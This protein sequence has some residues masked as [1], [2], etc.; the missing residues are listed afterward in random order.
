MQ[1]VVS[2]VGPETAAGADQDPGFDNDGSIYVFHGIGSQ[3]GA[4]E[5]DLTIRKVADDVDNPTLLG[6]PVDIAAEGVDLLVAEK[7]NN[8][9]AVLRY[10]GVL[11]VDYTPPATGAIA[12]D[13]VISVAAAEIVRVLERPDGAADLSDLADRQRGDL[14]VDLGDLTGAVLV[15]GAERYQRVVVGLDEDDSPLVPQPVLGAAGRTD[16]DSTVFGV[17]IDAAGT[18]VGTVANGPFG[19]APGG[20]LMAGTR[21]AGTALTPDRSRAIAATAA[22]GAQASLQAPKGID[23]VAELGVAFVADFRRNNQFPTG[24]IE[25]YRYGT[26]GDVAAAFEIDL[27]DTRPWDLDYDIEEDRLY[28]A[29]TNGSLLIFDD[30]LS[31]P[32]ADDSAARVVQP[33]VDGVALEG[34]LHGINHHRVYDADGGVL[35]DELI[36]SDVGLANDGTDGRVYV[37]SAPDMGDAA[38]AGL[39]DVDLNIDG[40]SEADG[41]ITSC[42]VDGING[43]DAA[44][45]GNPVDLAYSAIED[46]V[47]VVDKSTQALVHIRLERSALNGRADDFVA[48]C[49]ALGFAPE[50]LQLLPN[51]LPPFKP[52]LPLD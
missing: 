15:A 18:I 6:N 1:L 19:P 30:V 26:E 50:A 24:R 49:A 12:P 35:F 10:E 21:T 22:G 52:D 14:Y 3:L 32:P 43:N 31:N 38:F 42:N 40:L 17:D 2:D 25:A 41:Q 34:N 27:P 47:Y 36:L 8:G 7:A 39:Q 48:S 20:L 29:L 4:L 9:G 28:V 51:N 44:V 37:L 46:S 13:A 16:T 5:P 45:L 23:V 11:D 33:A